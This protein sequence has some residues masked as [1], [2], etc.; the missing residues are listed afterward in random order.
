M[1][2][3]IDE[4]PFSEETVKLRRNALLASLICLFIGLTEKL[5]EKIAVLGVSFDA[6]KQNLVGWFI[7]SVS[8]YLFI[9]FIS[10]AF[11]EVKQW[12]QP[13]L[14]DSTTRNKLLEYIQFDPTDFIDL[15]CDP[16]KASKNQIADSTRK[17][18][19][20]QMRRKLRFLNFFSY[21]RLI[22]ELI[23]PILVGVWGL[24]EIYSLVAK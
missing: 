22:I 8:L 6:P 7:F 1:S 19:E 9:H 5:P 2:F 17:D 15:P 24:V 14:I 4:S 13:K 23:V 21:L 20:W 18:V 3:S 11:I 16:H 12:I 10:V